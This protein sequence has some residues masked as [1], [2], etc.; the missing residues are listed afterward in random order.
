MQEINIYFF[1]GSKIPLPNSSFVTK[2]KVIRPLAV[3]EVSVFSGRGTT[4][5]KVAGKRKIPMILEYQCE[6]SC[7]G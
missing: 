5:P 6:V 2:R 4:H 1:Q 3:S 7:R